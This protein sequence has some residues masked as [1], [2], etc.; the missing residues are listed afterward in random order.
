M[1]I[2]KNDRPEASLRRSPGIPGLTREESAKLLDDL[3]HSSFSSSV[4]GMRLLCGCLFSQNLLPDRRFL[5]QGHLLCLQ[6]TFVSY[7]QLAT[8]VLKKYYIEKLPALREQY[9]ESTIA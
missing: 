4:S 1:Y 7:V 9:S 2:T 3:T 5:E 8:K 6:K